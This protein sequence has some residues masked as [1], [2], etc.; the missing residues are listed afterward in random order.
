MILGTFAY[1]G[2]GQDTL[3]DSFCELLGFKKYSMGDCIKYM[4]KATLITVCRQRGWFYVLS[5]D[6]TNL[7]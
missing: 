4:Y 7:F 1:C 3:A 6:E 5:K 2:S